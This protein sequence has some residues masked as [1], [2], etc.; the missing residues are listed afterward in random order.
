MKPGKSVGLPNDRL[1]GESVEAAVQEPRVAK[2]RSNCS[3]GG[4]GVAGLAGDLGVAHR[5]TPTRSG[6]FVDC[7]ADATAGVVACSLDFVTDEA[8]LSWLPQCDPPAAT[9]L[10]FWQQ[11]QKPPWSSTWQ[12]PHPEQTAG[13]LAEWSQAPEGT[14]I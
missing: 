4:C 13:A 7:G 8:A 1:A 9:G 14:V 3:I 12:C 2:S 6:C 5:Q 10:C 11:L